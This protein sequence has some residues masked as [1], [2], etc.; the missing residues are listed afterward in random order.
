[1]PNKDNGFDI[2]DL[3]D[4]LNEEDTPPHKKEAPEEQETSHSI[5]EEEKP[6]YHR[7]HKNEK[8]EIAHD[9]TMEWVEL[10]GDALQKENSS[11]QSHEENE[12]ANE[13]A[14]KEE[15][16]QGKS[17]AEDD[18]DDLFEW[19]EEGESLF[20][21]VEDNSFTYDFEDEFGN[22]PNTSS[23]EA[24]L[25]E[26][27]KT[28]NGQST[29]VAK[30]GH[31]SIPIHLILPAVIVVLAAVAVIRLAIWNAGI[32]I[33]I[34]SDSSNRFNVEVN[35]SMVILSS[36]DLEGAVDD[37][38]TTILCL[39]NEPFS[40][41][42]S[43]EGLAGQIASLGNC[44]VI[45]A[46]FPDSQVTCENATYSTDSLDEMDDIFNLFYVS[47]AISIDDYTSLATVASAHEDETYANAV[48]A[49]ENTDFDTVDIIAIMYDGI[50][51]R[52]GMSM[53]NPDL[54]EELTTYVGSLY[55]S[56]LLLREAYPH[57]RIVFLS[58]Y[59]AEYDEESSRTTDLGNGTLVDYFQW[60]YDTCGSSGISFID[61]YY[62]SINENNF[63]EYL[64]DGESLNLDGRIKIADHFV[65]KIIEGN[66]SEYNVEELAIAGSN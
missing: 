35:D 33:E 18:L 59:Y 16:R 60:A 2:L 51:Y 4:L 24:S 27:E 17:K 3:D 52:Y 21:H 63:E 64:V 29:E 45:N 13:G 66:Y 6:R 9:L 31:R 7:F 28:N 49:L 41:D 12:E 19:Y 39:G 22:R 53:Q 8:E 62:G 1:M 46:A 32:D 57:I 23:N 26:N 37:G 42:T 56:F 50:D 44:E 48:E 14:H 38:V 55:N 5:N 40:E 36:S 43:D 20:H 47:Y 25:T 15:D 65:Y 34:D 30:K 54:P 10:P 61:N 58:P 11:S